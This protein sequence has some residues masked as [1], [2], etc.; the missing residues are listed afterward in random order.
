M[1]IRNLHH[2]INPS[3]LVII[4]ASKRPGS[5]GHVVMNNVLASGFP[6]QIWPINPKY[7]E[8]AGLRC[9]AR[10]ADIPGVPDLAIIVTPPRTVPELVHAL[11]LHGTRTAVVITAGL[12]EDSGLKQAMLDAAKP[13]LFR[14]IGPNTVGMI[15]PPARLNASFAHLLPSTGDIALLSQSGAIAT[16]L[17]D[18]AVENNVGFSK[19]ISLG[20]MTDVDAGDFIDLLASDPGTR[21]IVLYLEAIPNP[22]KFLSAARAA[23]RLKPIVAIKS[24][25]H[26]E[27]AKAAATHTGAL[28]GGDQVTDAA[29]RRAGILRIHDLADLF[30]AAETIGRFAPLARSRVSIVTNGGGAGVLAVDRL[31]DLGCE[32]AEFSDQTIQALDRLLPATWSR[33]NPVD[34]IGDASP[35]RYRAAV[36]VVAQAPET[37]LL[38]IMNCPTGLASPVDAARAVAGLSQ[39]GVISTKPTLT[40]WLGGHTARDGRRVLQEAGL[41]SFD[42]PAD[43]ALAA[44]YLRNWSRAHQTLLRVPENPAEGISYDRKAVQAIFRQVATEKRQWL[45]ELEAKAAIAAYGIAVPQTILAK[46]FDEVEAVAT[47][48]LREAPAIAVKLVSS[49]ITHKSDVGGVA[50]DITSPFDARRGA[51]RISARLTSKS[52]GAVIDGF[53][54]QPMIKR[55]HGREL[56]LG[57]DR[58]PVFGPFILFGSGGITVEILAD[59]AIELPPLDEDLADDLIERTS[60]GKVLAGFRGEPPANRSSIRRALLAISQM[61]IDLPCIVSMDINPLVADAQGVIALD[62]RIGIDPKSVECPGPNPTLAI[63]PYPRDWQKT[64]VLK[65]RTYRIRPIK[66]TDAALYPAFLERTSG[67]DIRMRF[68]A[69]SKSISDQMLI[70]LTQI[71]YERELAFIALDFGTGELA[72]IARFSADPD[73]ECAEYGLLVRTD[74]QGLG[75]G[76]ALFSQ[77]RDYATADGLKWMEGIVLAENTKMLKLCREF[78]CS[79][80]D[81]PFDTRLRIATLL[82][83]S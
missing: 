23:A 61:I 34:I 54:V 55:E 79:I 27:A 3:S 29:F 58:D 74:L 75:I 24:G 83:S 69:A 42:T 18:W 60:I 30:D 36:E 5:L 52:S 40:C 46:S 39:S 80:A 82:L 47:D 35:E 26:P 15:I 10:V 51:E 20:D 45:T 7:E 64:V 12:G 2:A 68:L 31:M 62:A 19:V 76:W 14:I 77:L 25:R 63:R 22:R 53:A 16:A 32:L 17:I 56:I 41:A 71:D 21:A 48:I 72:G 66:P 67:D 6:G 50:L 81:H 1:T 57:I 28:C 59:S 33:A 38:L 65:G 73:H 11:G 49:A 13:F 78:G 9:F 70:R 8:I 4:G 37:D 44:S 43:A